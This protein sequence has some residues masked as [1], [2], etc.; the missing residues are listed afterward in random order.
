LIGGIETAIEEIASTDDV[1][2]LEE[3]DPIDQTDREE[4]EEVS[5]TEDPDDASSPKTK[6]N[7]TPK[8]SPSKE[9]LAWLRAVNACDL[10]L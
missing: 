6:S 8:L 4:I 1:E 9:L 7:C 3:T 5:P 2:G 10:L